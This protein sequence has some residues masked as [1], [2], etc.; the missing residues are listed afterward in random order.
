MEIEISD[1][2]LRTKVATALSVQTDAVERNGA[3]NISHTQN[4]SVD[5]DLLPELIK[6]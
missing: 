3:A 2:V 5:S 1:R 6:I 4:F